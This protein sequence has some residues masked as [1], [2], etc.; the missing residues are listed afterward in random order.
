M[1][2][3]GLSAGYI[4][5]VLVKKKGCYA[6]HRFVLLYF[7]IGKDSVSLINCEELPGWA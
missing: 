2:Q 6:G 4:V 5:E 7:M 1:D 3:E